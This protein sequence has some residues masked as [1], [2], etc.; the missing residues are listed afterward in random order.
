MLYWKT[1]NGKVHAEAE[2]DLHEE[3]EAL[4][5]GKGYTFFRC[6][7]ILNNLHQAATVDDYH[8]NPCPHCRDGV[9]VKPR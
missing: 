7:I 3:W 4:F 2:L 6:G 1:P 5:P 8:A 9:K